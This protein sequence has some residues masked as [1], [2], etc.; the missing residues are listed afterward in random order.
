ML[1]LHPTKPG[2]LYL[3]K[4]HLFYFQVITECCCYYK[5]MRYNLSAFDEHWEGCAKD[6]IKE[7]N[8]SDAGKKI[9]CLF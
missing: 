1:Q 2:L 8:D 5:D 9:L 7:C 6:N 3:D 4:S